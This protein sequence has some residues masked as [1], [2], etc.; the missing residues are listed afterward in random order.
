[1][2]NRVTIKDIAKELDISTTTVS[3]ALNG[4]SKISDETRETILQKAEQM[5]YKPNHIARAM[6]VGGCRIGVV[7]FEHPREYCYQI[8]YGCN[9]A[10]KELAD[11]R[12]TIVPKYVPTIL[13]ETLIN[14]ALIELLQENVDGIVLTGAS[15]HSYMYDETLDE[16]HKKNI[17]LLITT[18]K[19]NNSTSIGHINFDAN[20]AGNLAAQFLSYALGKG[21]PVV[22]LSGVGEVSHTDTSTQ[23]FMKASFDYG[24][25]VLG[26]HTTNDDEFIAYYLVEK[27]LKTNPELKGIYVNHFNSVSVCKCLEEHGRT[28][29]VVVGHDLFPE[30]AVKINLGS[31]DATIFSDPCEIGRRS[32]IRMVNAVYGY[33][34]NSHFVEK[35][36]PILIMKSNLP[37]YSDYLRIFGQAETGQTV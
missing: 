11:Y 13:S 33:E 17:P 20:V 15:S 32:M 26:I 9:Q 36:P 7:F 16:I 14:T 35:I 22:L 34:K 4:L 8:E 21:A 6:A 5:G 24:L 18:G 29:I 3:K 10:V 25:S 19:K 1:M 31:L 2:T 12:V 23:A 37:S 30:L 28:D 27:L